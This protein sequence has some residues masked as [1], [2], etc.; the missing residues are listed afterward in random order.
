MRIA[1]LTAIKLPRSIIKNN[2][3]EEEMTKI[4]DEMR[5]IFFV[6]DGKIMLKDNHTGETIELK[7]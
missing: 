3:Q 1:E 4:L 7:L 2:N 5:F 6:E